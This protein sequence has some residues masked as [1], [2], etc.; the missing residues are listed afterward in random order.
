MCTGANKYEDLR[1]LLTVLQGEV[2]LFV[3][4]SYATRPVVRNSAVSSYAFKS[5]QVGADELLLSHDK[6]QDLCKGRQYCYLVVA[7]FGAYDSAAV[8]SRYSLLASNKVSFFIGELCACELTWS[9]SLR[10]PRSPWP[11]AF[12]AAPPW[13]RAG[14]STSSTR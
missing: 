2:D 5:T 10:T 11:T 6:V 9:A 1:L 13:R 3:S 12:R 7:V 4:A 14:T 8:S